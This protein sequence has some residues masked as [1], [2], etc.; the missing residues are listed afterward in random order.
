MKPGTLE[1]GTLEQRV[2]NMG[3]DCRHCF[4]GNFSQLMMMS[5]QE[6][7]EAGNVFEKP[8][9]L[10]VKRIDEPKRRNSGPGSL[11][12]QMSIEVQGKDGGRKR[13]FY[14]TSE[15]W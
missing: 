12:T 14:W 11:R 6:I 3:A 1:P 10:V 8:E 4:L 15:Q 5:Y 2:L 13:W 9:I 7:F